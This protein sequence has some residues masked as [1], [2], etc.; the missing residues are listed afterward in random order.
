[1]VLKVRASVPYHGLVRLPDLAALRE[2]RL[3]WGRPPGGHGHGNPWTLLV[4]RAML[5]GPPTVENAQY[6]LPAEHSLHIL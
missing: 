6:G 1:M 3:R 2:P 4:L 5:V